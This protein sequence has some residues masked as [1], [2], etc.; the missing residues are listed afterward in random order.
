MP[1][2][3]IRDIDI[4]YE[5]TGDGEPLLFIHGLGSNSRAWKMQVPI[6][7]EHYKVITFDIRGHGQSG[8]SPGP[9][10]IET[11]VADTVEL[12]KSLGLGS[13]HV[14]GH[15][16]GGMIGLQL[17]TG[18]PEMVKS[19]VIM[20]GYFE[21][22]VRTFKDG[23]ECLKQIVLVGLTGMQKERQVASGQVFPRQDQQQLHQVI[24]QRLALNNKRAYISTFLA[25]LGW[26]AM[27]SLSTIECPVLVI[28]SDQDLVPVSVKEAYVSKI[29]HA[30]L[31][32]IANSRHATPTE[33]PE[34][35]NAVLREFLSKHSRMTDGRI[36]YASQA[37][38]EQ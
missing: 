6:F 2:L 33:Q 13:A 3:R 18:V 30:E 7:S 24:I 37:L 23:F 31:V 29:P 9:Y 5:V 1:K 8:K 17:C 25:L 38:T 26:S 32:V 21:G 4:Y 11:F 36:I 19:L 22:Y 15:S 20:N 14:V 34:K 12:M 16:L 27:D 28:A 35:F 10:S